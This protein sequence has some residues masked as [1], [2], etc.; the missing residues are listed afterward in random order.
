MWCIFSLLY[1]VESIPQTG[2][3]TV[4]ID[5]TEQNIP[6]LM[7]HS[8]SGS[9]NRGFRPCTVLPER[10]EEHLSYLEQY[11][12]NPITVTHFVQAMVCGGE[13]L[14]PRPVVLT[15]DDGYVDFY[16]NALP[17]LQRH[18]FTATLYIAT[19]FVGGTSGWLQGMGEG[20][21]SILSWSQ[22]T[23]ISA[24]GIECGAHSHT[25]PELDMLSSAKARDE[26]VRC[27][28]LLEEHLGQHVSS[29]AYPY[30]YY[31]ARVRRIVQE[32]GYSS[33]CAVRLTTSSLYDDPYALARIAIGP[34]TSVHVLAAA[35]TGHGKLISSPMKQVC[36]FVRQ[37][38]RSTYG[39]FHSSSR[40]TY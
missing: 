3:N 35:L 25:H 33:A 13:G 23:E 31:S 37:Y 24:S 29:F 18:G 32:T 39:R 21:R 40:A 14:P 4:I 1:E 30:G 12:Y 6:I 38:T 27:K 7:Y 26:I 28:H 11:H 34:D 36:S 5:V 15:F 16:T 22:L 9:A 19:A 20:S 17:A 8:I 10:F 2:G